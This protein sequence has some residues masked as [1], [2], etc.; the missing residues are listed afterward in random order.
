[1]T[2]TRIGDAF[3]PADEYGRSMPQF[4]VNLL[5][6][7]M[8]NSVDFYRDVIGAQVRYSDHDFAA[9]Q[10]NGWGFMLHADHTYDHHPL[11]ARLEKTGLRGSGA[12]LR[13]FGVDRSPG[14]A[15]RRYGPPSRQGLSAW[16][17]RGDAHGPRRLHLGLGRCPTR[18]RETV[19]GFAALLVT[20]F[21]VLSD[22]PEPVS[23]RG[24][25]HER[26]TSG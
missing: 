17:A 8:E 1:M 26:N 20:S 6:R 4:S 14:T 2:K 5:V 3:M 15:R 13:F 21:C 7:H 18:K 10:L 25:Q 19:T 11:F 24:A 16:L 12:E 9:L 22:S 23:D